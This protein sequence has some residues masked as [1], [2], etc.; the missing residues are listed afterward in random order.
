[1]F[2]TWRS[3]C[4]VWFVDFFGR[5]KNSQVFWDWPSW[6]ERNPRN[7][8]H[9]LTSVLPEVT[10]IPFKRLLLV[11]QKVSFFLHL[12]VQLWLMSSEGQQSWLQQ[13]APQWLKDGRDARGRLFAGECLQKVAQQCQVMGIKLDLVDYY[14]MYDPRCAC[15]SCLNR[16][17]DDEYQA[18]VKSGK[19]PLADPS[20]RLRLSANVASK[21]LWL[22]DNAQAEIA[23]AHDAHDKGTENQQKKQV[24]MRQVTGKSP[25]RLGEEIVAPEKDAHSTANAPGKKI[26]KT[27]RYQVRRPMVNDIL[28]RLG[29]KPTVDGFADEEL[30]VFDRWWGPGSSEVPDAFGVSWKNEPCLWLNPPFSVLGKVVEKVAADAAKVVLICPHW[31]D[32]Q[33][34]YDVQKMIVKRFFFKKGTF[35][36]EVR[37]GAVNG[38][39]WGVWALLLDGGKDEYPVRAL[40][41]M[42]EE[43]PKYARSSSS[44][45]RWRRKFKAQPIC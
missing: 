28:M 29:A 31:T 19:Q 21:S 34:F 26:P 4:S 18:W 39:P 10:R 43:D 33:W 8:L 14:G 20:G 36:F 17:A 41:K 15:K 38:I 27:E 42:D 7:A 25:V 1:M 44:T 24:H 2:W 13:D 32:Q 40:E 45:R 12:C 37:D 23:L 11:T 9:K 6:S 35:L 22:C 3:L 5:K 30:H 16:K